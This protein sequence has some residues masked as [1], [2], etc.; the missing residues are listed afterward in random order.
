MGFMNLSQIESNLKAGEVRILAMMTAKRHPNVPEIPTFTELGYKVIS[1]SS[2]GF[3]APA[4]I[5]EDAMKTLVET[6]EKVLADA[7][8]QAAAKEQLQMNVMNPGEYRAYL[9]ELLA[10]TNKAYEKDPW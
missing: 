6:F 2:R 9:E 1:D 5:P 4:G 8:F 10:V 3:A 7:E